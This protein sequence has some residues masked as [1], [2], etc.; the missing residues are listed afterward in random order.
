MK[1][2]YKA[3]AINLLIRAPIFVGMCWAA[4]ISGI[5]AGAF[6]LGGFWALFVFGYPGCINYDR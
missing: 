6:G 3:T 5:N 2:P 4:H 1:D